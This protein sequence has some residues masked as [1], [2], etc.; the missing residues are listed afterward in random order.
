MLKT[1]LYELTSVLVKDDDDAV[2]VCRELAEKDGIQSIVLCPGFTHQAIARIAD[3]TG[4]GV[5][6]CVARG[7]GPRNQISILAMKGAGW[8]KG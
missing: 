4:K 1:A 6:I 7:D 8:F 5:G 3:A 2:K